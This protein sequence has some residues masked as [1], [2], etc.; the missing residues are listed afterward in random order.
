MRTYAKILLAGA[1]LS[2][3]GLCA[4][5][6]TF[7][8]NGNPDV[9]NGTSMI[10]GLAPANDF[11]FGQTTSI[12]SVRFWTL[13]GITSSWDP[14]ALIYVFFADDGGTPGNP[15][16]G[17]NAGDPPTGSGS[18]SKQALGTLNIPG[19]GDSPYTQYQYDFDLVT[20][21]AATAATRY[22]LGLYLG[23]LSTGDILWQYTTN[24]FGALPRA[25]RDNA[26]PGSPDYFFET[27]PEETAFVLNPAP[28]PG[29][30]V[31]LLSGA[32]WMARKR[33]DPG[34]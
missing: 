27:V 9:Q 3:P 18:Y 16:A 24:A 4:A 21:F 14:E 20:P 5:V 2:L 15:I 32:F 12:T 23:S 25:N 28:A 34:R 19:L 7:D 11:E 13:E 1:L 22:W 33:P 6:P 30:L 29:T 31:L 26:S 8:A 17:D 10:G